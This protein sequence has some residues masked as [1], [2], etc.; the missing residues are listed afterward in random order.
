[1]DLSPLPFLFLHNWPLLSREF[2]SLIGLVTVEEDLLGISENGVNLNPGP[3][4]CE[5]TR[6]RR[7]FFKEKNPFR[8][9]DDDFLQCNQ[10]HFCPAN[11]GEH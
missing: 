7:S 2:S 4:L 3:A 6:L 1:M 5:R 10:A 9:E 8:D 11:P